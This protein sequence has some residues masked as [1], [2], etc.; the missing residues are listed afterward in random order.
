MSWDGK[1]RRTILIKS[2][3]EK[4]FGRRETDKSIDCRAHQLVEDKIATQGEAIRDLICD[5]KKRPSLKTII[6]MFTIMTSILGISY[7]AIDRYVQTATTSAVELL[8]EHIK[9]SNE[10]MEKT[11][12]SLHRLEMS[13]RIIIYR[14]DQLDKSPE[15]SAN[16][17][18]I[19]PD[20]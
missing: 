20:I 2:N 5:M 6:L 3:G 13:N 11:N 9:K 18:A 12:E 1:E 15:K 8:K 17:G 7:F 14:L 19:K 10:Q 4:I 16:R